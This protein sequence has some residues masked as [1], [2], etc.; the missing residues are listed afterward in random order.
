[1]RRCRRRIHLNLRNSNLLSCQERAVQQAFTPLLVRF[2][3]S[4]G[5]AGDHR[6]GKQLRHGLGEAFGLAD[7]ERAADSILTQA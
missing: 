7:T 2:N 1:M 4:A 6:D 3:D 5:V